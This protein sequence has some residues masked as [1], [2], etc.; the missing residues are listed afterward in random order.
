MPSFNLG[1]IF[2]GPAF[3]VLNEFIA[4]KRNVGGF[5]LPSRYELKIIPPTG[6]RGTEP[7]ANVNLASILMPQESKEKT[8]Q[9]NCNAL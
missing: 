6:T 5:A 4:E 2:E 8:V 7:G 3:G 9:K 1:K